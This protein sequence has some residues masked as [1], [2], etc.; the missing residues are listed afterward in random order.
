MSSTKFKHS[1]WGYEPKNSVFV[2]NSKLRNVQ[3]N[4]RNI[5]LLLSCDNVSNRRRLFTRTPYFRLDWRRI[6]LNFLLGFVICSYQG[7]RKWGRQIA[8]DRFVVFRSVWVFVFVFVSAHNHLHTSQGNASDRSPKWGPVEAM[9]HHP[10]SS[11]TERVMRKEPMQHW[12]GPG[13]RLRIDNDGWL[14]EWP[15][16]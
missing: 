7:H 13:C 2:L 4:C 12:W 5:S 11:L 9:I 8:W 14:K 3:K 6:L 1:F 15:S 16:Y 10:V